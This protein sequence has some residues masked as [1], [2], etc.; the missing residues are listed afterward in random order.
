MKKLPSKLYSRRTLSL[1]LHKIQDDYPQWSHVILILK[2]T[3]EP[4]QINVDIHSASERRLT[5]E[6]PSWYWYRT[7]TL[8][9]NTMMGAGAYR[10]NFVGLEESYQSVELHIKAQCQ[11]SKYHVVAKLCIPWTRGF[12][13]YH[14]FT[15]VSKLIDRHF[16]EQNH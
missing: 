7:Q 12:E 2:P 5:Y 3:K 10:I 16:S 8:T 1:D 13:R 14:Y 4:I 6:M 15:Y 11:K 9:D